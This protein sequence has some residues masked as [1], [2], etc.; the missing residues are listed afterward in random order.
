M[1]NSENQTAR[2]LLESF[3]QFS[4]L[5]WKHSPIAGLRPSEI[6]VL[7]CI[8]KM[9]AEGQSGVGVSEISN[10]LDVAPPTITQQ[11]KGLKARGLVR[12]RV[13][14]LDRRGVNISL[15]PKGETVINTAAEAM[16]AS[17]A[18]LVEDLGEKDS[19]ELAELL[20]RATTYFRDRK[21]RL[22]DGSETR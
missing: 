2:R 22:Q 5:H 13:N 14:K 16:V 4:R 10:R 8:R 9:T 3:S 17:F 21:N 6:M 15:T 19:N 11:V 18:G 1:K 12:R 20:S 7:Y